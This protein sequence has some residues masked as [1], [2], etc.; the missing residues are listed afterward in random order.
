MAGLMRVASAGET[1]AGLLWG[2]IGALG[3]AGVL[4]IGMIIARRR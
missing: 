4:G 1:P 2:G 3:L